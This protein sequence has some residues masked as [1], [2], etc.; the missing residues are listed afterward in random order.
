MSMLHFCRNCECQL[1]IVD[2]LP[3]DSEEANNAICESFVVVSDEQRQERASSPSKDPQLHLVNSGMSR[4]EK[5]I[6]LASRQYTEDFP[7][8]Q[9]CIDDVVKK[10]T[11]QTVEACNDLASYK[12]AYERLS[13]EVETSQNDSLI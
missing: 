12:Q 8:C 9:R 5:L 10:A 3:A 1:Q 6:Y 11:Q 13:Q 2:D 7:L 4:V